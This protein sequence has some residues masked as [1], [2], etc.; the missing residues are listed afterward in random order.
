VTAQRDRG[1]LTLGP[2]PVDDIGDCPLD[3]AG[4]S[5]VERVAGVQVDVMEDDLCT[6]GFPE[7]RVSV[8]SRRRA[9]ARATTLRMK[10]YSCSVGTVEMVPVVAGVRLLTTV[11]PHVASQ[12]VVRTMRGCIPATARRYVCG[13]G[14]TLG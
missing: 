8:A 1:H 6:P 7:N 2:D 4:V 3:E 11:C 13:W 14:E 9:V 5:V 10:G 12:N